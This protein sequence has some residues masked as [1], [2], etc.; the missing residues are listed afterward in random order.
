MNTMDY[1]DAYNRLLLDTKSYYSPIKEM[2]GHIG[3][4]TMIGRQYSLLEKSIRSVLSCGG[5]C[6]EMKSAFETEFE[7]LDEMV[8]QTLRKVKKSKKLHNALQISDRDLTS[9]ISDFRLVRLAVKA[10]AMAAQVEMQEFEGRMHRQN[11]ALL[12]K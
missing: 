10:K 9:L 1:K 5:Y 3:K 2:T 7:V 11:E 8:L 4:M 6:D 12:L